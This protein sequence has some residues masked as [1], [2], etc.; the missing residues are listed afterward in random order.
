RTSRR[1]SGPCTPPIFREAN[2]WP[3]PSPSGPMRRGGGSD[4]PPRPARAH[5]NPLISLDP[6]AGFGFLNAFLTFPAA[7][8]GSAALVQGPPA[9]LLG[10]PTTLARNVW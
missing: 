4:G 6:L 5:R 3:D 9:G 7:P 2:S 1:G 10:C 8:S